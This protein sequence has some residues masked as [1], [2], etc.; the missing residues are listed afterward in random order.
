MEHQFH[1]GKKFYQDKK[2]GYWISTTSPR[3]RAHVWVWINYFGN[4]E[5]GHHIHHIDGNKSNNEHSNLQ[6]LTAKEHVSKHDSP[7]RRAKNLVHINGIRQLT[8]EWHSSEEGLEWHREHG[9][10]TWDERKPFE[11]QCKY[12]GK[13]GETKIYHQDF[14]SNACKSS[15]RRKEGIDDIERQCPICNLKFRVN[16]YAKTQTCSRKCG[17]ILRSQKH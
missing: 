15:W 12:C 9:L 8:K 16:K 17:C 7:E 4:V 1:F 10:K 2:T 14:C 11:V 6:E 3:I 5:K 13:I